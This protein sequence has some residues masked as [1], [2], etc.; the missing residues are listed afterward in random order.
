MNQASNSLVVLDNVE[1]LGPVIVY[2]WFLIQ[3]LKTIIA[4][5][6]KNAWEFLVQSIIYFGK[7]LIETVE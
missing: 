3:A 1:W 4:L 5:Q 7:V 6:N 2:K